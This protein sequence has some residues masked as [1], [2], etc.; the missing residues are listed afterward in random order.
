MLLAI[1]K[2][3]ALLHQYQRAELDGCIIA[4]LADYEIAHELV[5]TPLARLLGGMTS[6]AAIRFHERLEC[7]PWAYE[8]GTKKLFTTTD[9]WKGDQHDEKA[10][11]TWL[12]ELEHIGS[13]ERQKEKKGNAFVW[14]LT[15]MP[16]SE[17]AAGRFELPTA[18][19]LKLFMDELA[20]KQDEAATEEVGAQKM[21]CEFESPF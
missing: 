20:A 12:R 15:D 18:E 16:H 21:E 19:E 3:S 13:V 10:V 7:Y 1:A 9:A 11:R 8:N 2:A 5:I 17:V 14:R 6:G 4:E